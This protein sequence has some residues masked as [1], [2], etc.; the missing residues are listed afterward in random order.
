MFNLR[1]RIILIFVCALFLIVINLAWL[2]ILI[3]LFILVYWT[4]QH[5]IEFI[6]FNLLK[7]IIRGALIFLFIFIS[8]ISF[9]ILICDVYKIPSPSMENLLYSGDVIVVNKLQYGPKLPRT[10]FEIPWVNLAF[11]MNEKARQRI[12]ENWWDY[13]RW[14][15]ITKIKQGDVFVFSLDRNRNFFVVKRCVGLP[16]DT[17]H[18]IKGEIYVN[19]GLFNSPQTVK[20]NYSFSIKNKSLMEKIIDSLNLETSVNYDPNKTNFGN[21]LFS[22]EELISLQKRYCIDSLMKNIDTYDDSLEKILQ[23]STSKWTLDDMGPIVIPK[24][25]MEIILN[26]DNLFLYKKIFNLFERCN[27]TENNGSFFV[28]GRKC[29]TY[30]FKLNYYFMIGDNRKVTSDSRSWGF[31]PESNIIGKVQFIL[32]SNRDEKFHWNRL[33]KS[34]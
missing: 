12:K 6:P 8:V 4:L 32:F 3:L 28:D 22:K 13:I 20:N 30:K 1:K 34:I 26:K 21:A 19:S 14:G 7:K 10:P 11:Y 31:L 29:N 9:K 17:I 23:T 24:K 5:L 25:D 16:G 33:F 27:V 2:F 15:G 18:L